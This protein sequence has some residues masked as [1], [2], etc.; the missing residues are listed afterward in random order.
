MP[1]LTYESSTSTS[2][3]IEVVRHADFQGFTYTVYEDPTAP[4]DNNT[5][6]GI[7]AGDQSG[8]II[9][10]HQEL[11]G[12]EEVEKTA[13][14]VC[15]KLQAFIKDGSKEVNLTDVKFGT[16]TTPKPKASA[17]KA[18]AADAKPTE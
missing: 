4:I 11:G 13:K 2:T 6:I 7:H 3:S 12:A 8:Q 18:K 16:A 14:A 5:R 10:N 9:Y 1:Y 17:S 15:A